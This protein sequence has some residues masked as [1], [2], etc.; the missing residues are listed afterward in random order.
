M[1]TGKVSGR[2]VAKIAHALRALY[3]VPLVKGR[4]IARQSL[5]AGR[6]ADPMHGAELEAKRQGYGAAARAV[7]QAAAVGKLER[8]RAQW[9][10]RLAAEAVRLAERAG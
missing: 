9:A 6:H 3:G 10:D 2:K 7:R 4:A 5:E 1:T 8:L